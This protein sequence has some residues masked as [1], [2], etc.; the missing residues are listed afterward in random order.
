VR[1][2]GNSTALPIPMSK[3]EKRKIGHKV[4]TRQ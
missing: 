2:E 4:S 1:N 3:M